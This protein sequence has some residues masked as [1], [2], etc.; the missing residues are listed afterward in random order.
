[1]H[2]RVW[3]SGFQ[4]VSNFVQPRRPLFPVGVVVSV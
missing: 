1:M 2:P 3:W 4:L